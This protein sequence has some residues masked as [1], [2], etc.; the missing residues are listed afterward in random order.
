MGI[1]EAELL[2]D[3]LL[4]KIKANLQSEFMPHYKEDAFRRI[5]VAEALQLGWSVFEPAARSYKGMG[6][7]WAAGI[8]LSFEGGVLQ[9][10]PISMNNQPQ[11]GKPDVRMVD[12]KGDF[13]IIEMK[14]GFFG[15]LSEANSNFTAISKDIDLVDYGVRD[16]FLGLFDEGMFDWIQGCRRSG[17]YSTNSRAKLMQ[18]LFK[19]KH[20]AQIPVGVGFVNQ[21]DWKAGQLS[22]TVHKFSSA[23]N[24]CLGLVHV[25]PA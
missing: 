12:P 19:K 18:E 6:M 22:L 25:R 9:K 2:V 7:G 14:C 20:L 16:H 24:T 3:N 13:H 11:F 15:S 21:V 10:S 8:N 1:L 23:C 4:L 17:N 5:L